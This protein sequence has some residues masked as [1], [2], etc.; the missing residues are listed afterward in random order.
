MSQ[1]IFV[2]SVLLLVTAAGCKKS[3][4]PGDK[5]VTAAPTGSAPAAAPSPANPEAAGEAESGESDYSKPALTEA[6]VQ[7]Y[8]KA[9]KDGH[10][11]FAVV[12]AAAGMMNGTESIA[13]AQ[14]VVDEQEAI[15]K[16][17]GFASSEDYMETAGRIMVGQVQLGAAASM[18]QIRDMTVKTIADYEKQLSDPS[19]SA[20]MKTSLS[21]SLAESKKA[22]AEMDAGAKDGNQLNAA[23]LELVKK[24]KTEIEA[25]DKANAEI[26]KARKK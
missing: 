3:D 10:N 17:Y 22:L 9:M 8:I 14:A 4:K 1:R 19:L 16:K 13:N 15:A 5:Q 2:L 25:A 26:L 21:E 18:D 23:D 7:G 11:P 24:F 6:K 20:E 12:G